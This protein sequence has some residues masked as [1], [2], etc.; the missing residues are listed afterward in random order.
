MCICFVSK[1]M[2]RWCTYLSSKTNGS[3]RYKLNTKY[4]VGVVSL[5]MFFFMSKHLATHDDHSV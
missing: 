3:Q 5:I 2:C 4:F 1:E